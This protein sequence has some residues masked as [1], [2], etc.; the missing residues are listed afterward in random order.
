MLFWVPR[1]LVEDLSSVD[2]N[3]VANLAYWVT[4][5]EG[6]NPSLSATQSRIS[7]ILRKHEQNQLAEKGK[8]KVAVLVLNKWNRQFEF[9]P[10]RQSVSDDV[11][12]LAD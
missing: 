3:G 5:T 8:S 11:Y 10:L 6:S 9:T 12:S 1:S 4:G 7:L 2:R